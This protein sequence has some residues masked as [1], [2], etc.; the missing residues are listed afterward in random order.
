MTLDFPTTPA[1][2]LTPDEQFLAQKRIADDT[3]NCEQKR[4]PLSGLGDALTD[5]TLWWLAA[6]GCLLLVGS[7]FGLF[8]PTIAATMGYSPEVTLLLCVPPWFIGVT[9]SFFIMRS[10]MPCNVLYSLDLCHRHSDVTRD[11]FWH[12]V[13]P[14]SMGVIGFIIAILTMDTSIRYLS[15]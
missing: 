14:I 9:A 8:F 7:S 11:R 4:A 5:W 6:A 13:G 12:I 1:S 2:W 10:V 3:Y 15:L